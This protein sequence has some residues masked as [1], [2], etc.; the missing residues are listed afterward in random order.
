MEQILLAYGL[1]KR[2]CYCYN[3]A[4]QNTKAR[5]GYVNTTVQMHHLDANETYGEKARWE[6]DKNATCCFEQILD[7]TP[8]KTAAV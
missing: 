6:Q 1:P 3:D 7:A 4:Y 8:C 2:N 5:C